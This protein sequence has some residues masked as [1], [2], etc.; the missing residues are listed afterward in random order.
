MEEKDIIRLIETEQ[1]RRREA[2]AEHVRQL[3]REVGGDVGA[4]CSTWRHAVRAAAMALLLLLPGTL[5]VLLPQ[6]VDDRQV[7]CNQ[8]G[9]EQLVLN[10]AC[11]VV[12]NC[13]ERQVEGLF[14]VEN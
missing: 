10:R 11:S 9:E 6:R 3:S 5:F 14:K 1:A 2:D 12:G 7:L 8:R 4:W 13:G